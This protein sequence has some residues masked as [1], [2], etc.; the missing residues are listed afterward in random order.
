MKKSNV[1]STFDSWLREENIYEEVSAAALKRVLARQL[2]AAMKEKQFSK[3]EMARR[4]HTSRAALDRLLDP[5][6]DAVTLN[7][8]RKAAQALGRQLRLELV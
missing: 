4:M 3:A 1:G 6:Y 5:D 2:A 8:L 7:T